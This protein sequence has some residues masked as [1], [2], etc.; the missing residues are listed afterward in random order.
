MLLKKQVTVNVLMATMGQNVNMNAQVEPPILAM[1]TVC[2][3]KQLEPVHVMMEHKV[4]IAN[5]VKREDLE[6]IVQ[7]FIQLVKH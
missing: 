6:Q 2:V 5:H 1:V 3:T 4:M 7:S